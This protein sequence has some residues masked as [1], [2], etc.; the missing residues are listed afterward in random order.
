MLTASVTEPVPWL[1]RHWRAVGSVLLLLLLAYVIAAMH[2]LPQWLVDLSAG[3]ADANTKLTAVDNTRGALLGILTPIV[4]VLGS[5][6]AFLNF[7]ETRRQNESADRLAQQD[8]DEGRR[9]RRAELYAAYMAAAVDL[10]NAAT[11]AYHGRDFKEAQAGA[12]GTHTERLLKL[13][14]QQQALEVVRDRLRLLGAE[15]VQSAADALLTHCIKL[16]RAAFAK[17]PPSEEEYMKL[18]TADYAVYW[19]PFLNA[20]RA[21]LGPT[22]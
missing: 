9:L 3:N 1:Y 18:A 16:N 13:A 19:L 10:V 15:E 22:R 12:L 4:I 7:R 20:A 17:E 14:R 2:V 11:D 21:D 6:A 8:R 5:V